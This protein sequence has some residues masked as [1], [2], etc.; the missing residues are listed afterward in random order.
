MIDLTDSFMQD[1]EL[2][3]MT[4]R[5]MVDSQQKSPVKRRR[6]Q[7]SADLVIQEVVTVQRQ[8]VCE[9]EKQHF[10]NFTFTYLFHGEIYVVENSPF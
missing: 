2:Q 8:G 10:S 6:L 1:Y 4:Y 5:A 9:R 7:S 3:T